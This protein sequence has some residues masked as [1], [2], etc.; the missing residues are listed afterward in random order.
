M[1]R[2][3]LA[4]W[5]IVTAAG[6]AGLAACGG[7]TAEPTLDAT[8]IAA[9]V[10][11]SQTAAAQATGALPPPASDTPLPA[12]ATEAAET[13]EATATTEPTATGTATASPTATAEATPTEGAG[14]VGGP[15]SETPG[16]PGTITGAL[17]YPSEVIPR[18]RVYAWDRDSGQWRYVITNQNDSTYALQ[19]PPGKYIVFAYLNDGGEIAGGYT[20]AVL[21]GLDAACTDHT[22]YVVTVGSGQQV[23]GV[24]VTDW[25]GPPGSIP[26]PPG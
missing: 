8:A 7:G 24:N 9:S 5:I 14:P 4:I 2:L 26:Q 6:A 19:V 23:S 11:Q 25:Y 22:L 15:T 20:H 17:G 1:G 12:A 3:R 21:C 13:L 18:L 10:Q 16:Q